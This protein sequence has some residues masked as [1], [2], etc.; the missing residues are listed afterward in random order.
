MLSPRDGRLFAVLVSE[1][2]LLYIFFDWLQR[3]PTTL[4]DYCVLEVIIMFIS[5][6]LLNE[7]YFPQ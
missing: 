6:S 7:K 4:A 3:F 2:C 5:V 1:S